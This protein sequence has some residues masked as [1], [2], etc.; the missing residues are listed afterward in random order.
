M[1]SPSDEEIARALMALAYARGVGKSF[2]PSEAARRLS[3]DWRPLMAR[4]RR[5]AIELPLIASQ[6]GQAV[7]ICSA[8]GPI[9]LSLDRTTHK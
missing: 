1:T 8:R 6:K 4:V 5:V 7:D 3:E 9:R 2:C